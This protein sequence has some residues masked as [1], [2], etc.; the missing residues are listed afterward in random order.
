[1][2][3]RR[4][5]V[6]IPGSFVV[7]YRDITNEVSKADVTQTKN[8]SLGGL[9]FST[10]RQFE[11]GRILE[12]KIKLPTSPD[13]IVVNVRV[14]DSKQIVKNLL[15]DTRVKFI[16]LKEEDRDAIRKLVE[17]YS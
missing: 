14:V 7:F 2:F 13:Y 6:R 3:E 8:I 11:A 5:F 17:H 4:R 1:M 9:L 12:L 16:S 10:D 15:S